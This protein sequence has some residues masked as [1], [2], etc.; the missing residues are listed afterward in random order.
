MAK[1][2]PKPQKPAREAKSPRKGNRSTGDGWFPLATAEAIFGVARQTFHDSVR[3]KL[4]AE[5]V[6]TKKNLVQIH[7][8]TAI[9]TLKA[10]WEDRVRKEMQELAGDDAALLA[11][12]LSP[13]LEEYRKHA[14][15]EKKWKADQLERQAVP[16]AELQ[17][18]LASLTHGLRHAGDTLARQYG[19]EA[20]D[21]LNE[22]VAEWEAAWRKLVVI[23]GASEPAHGDAAAVPG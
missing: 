11:G 4:P 20:A 6:R 23:D 15:R 7:L 13:N 3:S 16:L 21:V 12:G 18:Q 9:R 22:A 14:A 10:A 8:P 19:N 5:A 17:P 1:P 2:K